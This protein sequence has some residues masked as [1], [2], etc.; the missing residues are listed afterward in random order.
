M[1][2]DPHVNTDSTRRGAVRV[3]T[4]WPSAGRAAHM[5]GMTT[6]TTTF[7]PSRHPRGEAG[8]PGR[9]R[10]KTA[11][12]PADGLAV[13]APE[14]R[15]VPATVR[16][17]RWDGDDL[18][19]VGRVPLDVRGLLDTMPLGEV[20][21]LAGD[22]LDGGR[23]DVLFD[24]IAAAGAG[25]AAAHQG[26]F[27]VDLDGEHLDEYLQGR[28]RDGQEEPRAARWVRP[29]QEVAVD[30]EQALREQAALA[31]LAQEGVD[32]VAEAVVNPQSEPNLFDRDGRRL[33]VG[34]DRLPEPA[35]ARIRDVLDS[36]GVSG[37]FDL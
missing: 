22:G 31:V 34:S 2:A 29:L 23:N 18:V 19:E 5:A 32:G 3:P 27:D 30:V 7:D 33:V 20:R 4:A 6:T 14:H 11:T 35:A 37:A 15:P 10:A 36:M 9:F 1:P 12:P 13:A 16:L 17:E 26:P 25:P 21:Q 28:E 8:N 24:A